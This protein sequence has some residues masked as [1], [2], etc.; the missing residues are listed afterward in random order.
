MDSL[1]SV[2]SVARRTFATYAGQASVLLPVAAITVVV[3]A[4]VNAR[5]IK[6]SVILAIGALI[7][8]LTV[9]ALFTATVVQRAAD[10]WEGKSAASPRELLATVRPVLGELI[11]VGFVAVV[12]ITFFYSVASLLF[13]ALA[14]GAA[15]GIGANVGGIAVIAVVGAILLLAPGTYMLIVWSV[16]VP[17][18]VLERPGGL[19]ALGR[20][21]DLVRGHRWRVLGLVVLFWV[22]L[23]AGGR[24]L[25]LADRVAGHGPG[26][27]AQLIAAT[28]I[29]PIP[30]LGATALYFELRK[31]AATDP[32]RTAA[33][34]CPL[35]VDTSPPGA[36]P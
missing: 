8:S 29:V 35:P 5:P 32:P 31:V 1:I 11:L 16:A 27:A 36:I 33:S 17:V 15:V 10:A 21:S 2:R 34:P 25:G 18:V 13:L 20:S 30:L 7:V 12:A 22:A 26:L 23:G 14:I 4:A 28:L 19:R 9:M 6:D 24:A 3:V